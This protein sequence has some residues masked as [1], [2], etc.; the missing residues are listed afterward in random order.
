MDLPYNV[1]LQLDGVDVT[2]PAP[3]YKPYYEIPV[4]KSAPYNF[5]NDDKYSN[6][7]FNDRYDTWDSQFKYNKQNL[8]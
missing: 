1:M 3:A 5:R 7:N 8:A 6:P 2:K 4:D